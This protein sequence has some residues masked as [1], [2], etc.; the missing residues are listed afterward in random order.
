MRR[1]GAYDHRLLQRSV[2][3]PLTADEIGE[4]VGCYGPDAVTRLR[5]R[6]T[7]AVKIVGTQRKNGKGPA[8]KLYRIE[9]REFDQ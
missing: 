1:S 9:R 7:L 3:H 4:I 2:D 6:K 8:K 5:Q